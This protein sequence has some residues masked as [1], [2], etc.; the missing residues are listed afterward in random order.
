MEMKKRAATIAAS[1][2]IGVLT[3]SGVPAASAESDPTPGTQEVVEQATAN[4]GVPAASTDG[5]LD[6]VPATDATDGVTVQ[7]DH[8]APLTIPLPEGLSLDVA[9]TTD[10]GSTIYPADRGSVDVAVEEVTQG[11]RVSTVLWDGS[12]EA[13]S[14]SLP[15]GVAATPRPDGS[16]EL[17]RT[18]VVEAEGVTAEVTASI[19]SIEPAWAIDADG[20]ALGT[21]YD[22]TNGVITQ[23]VDLAGAAFPVVADPTWA[24]TSPVQVRIRFTRAETATIA[25]G[26]W[27]ATGLTAVCA[28]AGASVAGPPGAAAFAAGCFLASGAMVYTAGVAQNSRPK[29]CLEQFMTFVPLSGAIIGVPWYGTYACR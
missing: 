6:V 25:G 23:T 5:E 14:Y 7:S 24:I 8:L 9:E 2:A 16:L 27:H 4:A 20:V 3:L 22:V 28:A 18:E 17:T 29:R 21:E 19:G 11:V 26:G 13:F 12:R 1:L 15:E 10:S